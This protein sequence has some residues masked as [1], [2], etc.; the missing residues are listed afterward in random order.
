MV[1]YRDYRCPVCGD[2]HTP[3]I[4]CFHPTRCCKDAPGDPFSLCDR[5]DELDKLDFWVGIPR[6]DWEDCEIPHSRLR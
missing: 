3:C 6:D 1:V 4:K 2:F 5:C